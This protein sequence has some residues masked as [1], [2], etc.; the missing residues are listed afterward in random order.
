MIRVRRGLRTSLLLVLLLPTGSSAGEGVPS[1]E[2]TR[3]R[4]RDFVARHSG[5]SASQIRVPSLEDFRLPD[6]TRGPVELRLSAGDR[7]DYHGPTPVTLSFLAGG[8]EIRRGVVTVDVKR[9]ARALVA[10]RGLRAGQLVRAEDIQEVSLDV[11]RVPRDPVHSPY[12]LVGK[13]TTRFVSAGTPWSDALVSDPPAVER[14]DVVTLRLVRGALRIEKRGRAREDGAAGERIRVTGSD[15]RRE[16]IG[17][18]GGDGV[19]YVPF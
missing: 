6:E 5:A 15:S 18:V 19:V 12:E 9:S 13:R 4:V 7:E 2:E 10:S 1:P 8:Q 17:V 11:N 3:S 14:G 16:I